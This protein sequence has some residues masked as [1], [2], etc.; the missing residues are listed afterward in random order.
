MAERAKFNAVEDR[1]TNDQRRW[2]D[3]LLSGEL[4]E[5]Q[6]RYNDLKRSAKKA[7]RQHLVHLLEQLNWLESLPDSDT[8]LDGV[9]AT[10]LKHL[11]EMAAVLDAGEMKGLAQAKRHTLTFALIR[12]MRVRARDDI[13]EMFIRRIGACHPIAREELQEIQARLCAK[14]APPT[15]ATSSHRR[16]LRVRGGVAAESH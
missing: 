10:R 9:P 3:E 5:R 16:A 13:A 6:T 2:L 11:S 12:Q 8:L 14:E 7:S 4:P 1:L 15:A